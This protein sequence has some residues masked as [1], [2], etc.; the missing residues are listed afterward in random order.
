M[1][2]P[3][4]PDGCWYKLIEETLLDHC[5]AIPAEDGD[6]EVRR[7]R[8]SAL[9]RTAAA[10]AESRAETKHP[11]WLTQPVAAVTVRVSAITPTGA[12]E[13]DARYA[14]SPS[15]FDR[16][17]ALLRGTLVHRLMQSL[18]DIAPEFRAEAARRYLARPKRS[19]TRTNATTSPRRF[20][21]SS[22]IRHSCRF[23]HKA[24][25]RKFRSW[26][27]RNRLVSGQVD[28]LVVTDDASSSPITRPTGPAQQLDEALKIHRGYARQLALYGPFSAA[29]IPA[30]RSGRP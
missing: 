25:A 28:R 10:K 23:S 16:E 5:D 24:A 12:S 1:A 21:R 27:A 14:A 9:P 6:G 29:F 17:S 15:S 3:S 18:P 4:I 22:T 7:F 13:D 8:K 30:T 11:S 20:S 26:S 19:S 2:R